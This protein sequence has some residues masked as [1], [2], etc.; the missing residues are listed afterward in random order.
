MRIQ[1]LLAVAGVLACSLVLSPRA[2]R[3]DGPTAAPIAPTAASTA[4]TAS[5][6]VAPDRWYGYVN[7]SVDVVSVAAASLGTAWSYSYVAA[8][9]NDATSLLPF[10]TAGVGML[11]FALGSP[12]VHLAY[13]AP[14]RAGLSF[15]LRAS[16]GTLFVAALASD[17]HFP[18]L[19][20]AA[21]LSGVAVLGAMAVDDALLARAHD[22]TDVDPPKSVPGVLGS[23][24]LRPMV[25]RKTRTGGLT[26][27]AE[28]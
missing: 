20:P 27:G 5:T 25:A 11:G 17:P 22:A 3:A 1:P 12:V 23:L 28:F 16:T 9:G 4:S 13:G 8:E 19:T 18:R 7:L 21:A 26:L 10:A 15:L 2:A 24:R 14:R 6:E